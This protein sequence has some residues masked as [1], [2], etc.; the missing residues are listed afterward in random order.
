MDLVL[1]QDSSPTGVGFRFEGKNGVLWEG[2]MPFRVEEAGLHHV[3]RKMVGLTS[4]LLTAAQWLEDRKIQVRVDSKSTV[5]YVRDR[6]GRSEIMTF[7]TRH[8]W[9]IVL[10]H[11]IS[12][13]AVH[14]AGEDM[15]KCGVDGLSRPPPPRSLSEADRAGWQVLPWVWEHVQSTLASRIP[16]FAFTFD[17]FASRADALLPRFCSRQCEPGAL[18]PPNAFVPNWAWSI[19]QW[20]FNW[21]FPPSGDISR[22]FALVREQRAWACVLVPD[23][24][25]D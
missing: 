16:G 9:G 25:R 4:V 13:V 23:W 2:H 5:K 19:G 8:L 11:R 6:G 24:C 12:I 1:T 10:R 7:L 20:E 3:Y 17:R 14:I 21:A 15:V 18:S 22:V